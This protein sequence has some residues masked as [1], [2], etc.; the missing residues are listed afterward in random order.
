[1]RKDSV[2]VIKELKGESSRIEIRSICCTFSFANL[3][4]T[5]SSV[6][7][8]KNSS[9]IWGLEGSEFCS[10][11]IILVMVIR[12]AGRKCVAVVHWRGIN[13]E[14][15]TRTC[16]VIYCEGHCTHRSGSRSRRRPSILLALGHT[17]IQSECILVWQTKD[18]QYFLLRSTH[19]N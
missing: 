10:K 5:P 16:A 19:P 18:H 3:T 9:E 13:D 2:D 6:R 4:L 17:K 11:S 1:V 15:A 14:H 12:S 8:G 7:G